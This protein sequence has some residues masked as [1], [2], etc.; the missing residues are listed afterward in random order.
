M[1]QR[2]KQLLVNKKEYLSQFKPHAW[3]SCSKAGGPGIR[4]GPG[5]PEGESRLQRLIFLPK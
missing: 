1:V 4:G 3:A 5:K 2:Y